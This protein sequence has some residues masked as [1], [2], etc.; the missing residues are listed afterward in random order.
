VTVLRSRSAGNNVAELAIILATYNEADNL[1]RLI[2][3]LEELDEDLH[4][5]VVDDNSPDGTQRVA[6]KLSADYGNITVV[7]RPRKL[8]LG[9]ALR[10]GIESALATDATYIMTM[11]ADY[12]HDPLD[13]PRLMGVM[14]DSGVDMVQ[15]SRYVRGGGVR[16]WPAHRMVLSRTANLLYHWFAG[17]PHE[18][19]TNFRA[20][21]RGA[22]LCVATRA[23]C[24]G[25]D[26][27]PEATLLVLAA[28][29]TIREIPVVFTNR[30]LGDSKLGMRQT[31][32]GLTS[33]VAIV[34]QYRLRLGRY[35]RR[36]PCDVVTRE[37]H[38]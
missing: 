32:K 14:R 6:Q 31:I 12:S 38:K 28:G 34:L 16:G 4:I 22:A 25:Y 27:V 19:T 10:D 35:A 2:R 3:A 21:S 8:G 17:A 20:M 1:P 37:L 30:V 24:R 11:D 9:S 36:P 33:F 7:C 13:V 26:F 23:R 29:L 18:S 5:V 15:G